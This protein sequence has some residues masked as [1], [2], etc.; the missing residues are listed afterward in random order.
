[1]IYFII[2]HTVLGFV[3]LK[4]MYGDIEQEKPALRPLFIALILLWLPTIIIGLFWASLCE[5]YDILQTIYKVHKKQKPIFK[6]E[7]DKEIYKA[8]QS[9][10]KKSYFRRYYGN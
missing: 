3:F 2:G 4:L 6:D 7:I 10:L 5:S 8:K 1:M 9:R